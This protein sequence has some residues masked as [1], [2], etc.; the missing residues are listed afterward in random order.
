MET[1]KLVEVQAGGIHLGVVCTGVTYR[2]DESLRTE[3]KRDAEHRD[4]GSI[5]FRTG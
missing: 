1:G 2:G 3:V 4:L 5:T